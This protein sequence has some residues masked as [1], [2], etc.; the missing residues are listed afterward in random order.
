M[1]E[2][3]V[4]NV[5]SVGEWEENSEQ[6]AMLW[7][8]VY[9]LC[10]ESQHPVSRLL[11]KVALEHV[12]SHPCGSKSATLSSYE[13]QPGLGLSGNVSSEQ[14]TAME[15][16]IGNTRLMH[17]NN[18]YFAP[19]FSKMVEPLSACSFVYISINGQLAARVTYYDPITPDAEALIEALHARG[20]ETFIMTGDTSDAA[21]SVAR[22]VGIKA[23]NVHSSLSPSGKAERIVR[24][25]R[26]LGP[27][28]MIG[29]NVNDGPA[30][31]AATLGVVLHSGDAEKNYRESPLLAS[32]RT[33]VDAFLLPT[34]S[35]NTF[36]DVD[37]PANETMAKLTNFLR[38]IY[39]I[40]LVRETD[41]CLKQ[42]MHWSISYNILALTLAGGILVP[43]LP[44]EFAAWAS[45]T[46]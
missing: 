20:L 17:A 24:L 15:V 10:R 22:Q 41:Q 2:L 19:A 23:V 36:E 26:Q 43:F 27:V 16:A 7:Q 4:K 35:T 32:L 34:L 25:E 30:L 37:M 42:V 14:T 12:G 45:L 9:E 40:D 33:D 11:S 28:I 46:P 18:V 29:D 21:L 5:L 44:T 31:F 8:A 39:L 13:E 38:I 6:R 3:V 1:G